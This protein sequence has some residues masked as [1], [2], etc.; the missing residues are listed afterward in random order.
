MSKTK[1]KI[2]TIFPISLVLLF[3]ILFQGVYNQDFEHKNTKYFILATLL[4]I[5]QVY[6]T[7]FRKNYE[8]TIKTILISVV[9]FNFTFA[10][11]LLLSKNNAIYL[12]ELHFDNIGIYAI[13]ISISSIIFMHLSKKIN[14]LYINHIARTIIVIAILGIF[15]LGSR[16]ALIVIASY[17]IFDY[18][19]KINH[20]KI[21]YIT[22]FALILILSTVLTFSIKKDSSYGRFFV[23]KTTYIMFEDNLLSGIG[24]GNFASKYPI[25]QASMY[26]NKKMSSREISL[27]DNT[28]VAFNEFL[29]ITSELGIIGIIIFVLLMIAL[30]KKSKEHRFLYFSIFVAM[31][32]SYI[33]HSSVI[34]HMLILTLSLSIL[35]VINLK[36]A[37][38]RM[39]ILCIFI[40]AGVSLVFWVNKY[41]SYMVANI[42]WKQSQP[43]INT[44]YE[45]N[46][47]YLCDNLNLLYAMAEYNYNI[48]EFDK[49][50]VLLKQSDKLIIRNETELLKGKCYFKKGIHDLAEKHLR[51]S[52]AICPN[53]F[54]NRYELFKFYL[55]S[56]MKNKAIKEAL[57]IH[58]LEE[59][60]Q[61]IH[62]IV[63]KNYIA[64]FLKENSIISEK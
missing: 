9:A 1:I 10:L 17:L 20:S 35:P 60:I 42:I 58:H 22:G 53:R 2:S 50:L 55:D 36:P 43:L 4:L 51:L 59:K 8:F 27:A 52:V 21:R 5:T 32:F 47:I 37:I 14:T 62:T 16:T 38:S 41:R 18:L 11:K 29:H 7:I 61:S 6:N 31:F 39:I 54:I 19:I 13:F 45:K 15:I 25:Y 40:F 63:I 34:T 3:Y 57:M 12:I 46:R 64:D 23:W 26:E 49:A 30:L 44:Y 48:K 33:L 28:K 56:D 24:Y